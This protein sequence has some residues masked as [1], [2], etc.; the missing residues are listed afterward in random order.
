MK[1][2][3]CIALCALAAILACS[4]GNDKAEPFALTKVVKTYE[5]GNYAK[6]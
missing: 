4:C 2:I 5:V 6:R 1:R 3:L